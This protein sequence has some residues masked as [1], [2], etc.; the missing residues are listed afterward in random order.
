MWFHHVELSCIEHK[1][2]IIKNS[3]VYMYTRIDYFYYLSRWKHFKKF[4]NSK[5]HIIYIRS[6][7]ILMHEE[8]LVAVELVI[9]TYT[10][11][12]ATDYA[13]G[14][15]DNLSEFKRVLCRWKLIDCI[16]W[17]I[18]FPESGS[19]N[20]VSVDVGM[21]VDFSKPRKILLCHLCSFNYI[22]S[23]LSCCCVYHA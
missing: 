22:S 2:C 3:W 15:V 23:C 19:D 13:I 18:V 17:T 6:R 12:Y 11:V 9:G 20:S 8:Y 7:Y 16:H 21:H 1:P 10:I 4:C 5:C 14:K